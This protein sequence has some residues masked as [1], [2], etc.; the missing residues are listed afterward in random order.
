[1]SERIRLVRIPDLRFESDS[2]IEPGR[3]DHLLKRIRKGRPRD[4]A[5]GDVNSSKKDPNN[6]T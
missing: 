6:E 4:P 3:I 5:A 1:L 2:T